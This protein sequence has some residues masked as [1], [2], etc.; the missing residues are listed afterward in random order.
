[1]KRF[2]KWKGGQPWGEVVK[3]LLG[4]PNSVLVYGIGLHDNFNFPFIRDKVID[5]MLKMRRN[6]S[7]PRIVWFTPHVPGL[8]KAMA[9][10]GQSRE[11]A[12][13]YAAQMMSY[14]KGKLHNVDSIAFTDGM[15]SYDGTHYGKAIN[16]LKVRILLTLIDTNNKHGWNMNS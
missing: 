9:Y 15:V 5:P 3:G 1:M 6:N 13:K 4:K 14:L 12:L 2:L 10:P 8:L 16:D 11:H 7:W